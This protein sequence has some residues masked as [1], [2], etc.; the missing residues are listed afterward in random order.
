MKPEQILKHATKPKSVA[1]RYISDLKVISNREHTIQRIID[2][3]G[4]GIRIFLRK[5]HRMTV[6]EVNMLYSILVRNRLPYDYAN[7]HKCQAGK[8][9]FENISM[10]TKFETERSFVEHYIDAE[11]SE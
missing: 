5:E 9:F 2:E 8:E 6:F 3:D 1:Q 11:V 7:F 4:I 10:V